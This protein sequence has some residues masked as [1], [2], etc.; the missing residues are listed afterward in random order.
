[1]AQGFALGELLGQCREGGD[2][3]IG[4]VLFGGNEAELK[5]GHLGRIR[6]RI[7]LDDGL[8]VLLGV[9]KVAGVLAG[10]ATLGE[11]LGGE[12]VFWVVFDESREGANGVLRP[13]GFGFCPTTIEECAG[14]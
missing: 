9:G 4:I 6:V 14:P 12:I 5:V 11:C 1:M 2:H 8:E 10:E 13:A 3:G 7:L